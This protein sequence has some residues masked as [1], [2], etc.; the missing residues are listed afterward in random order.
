M[1]PIQIKRECTIIS[2]R[3]RADIED[4]RTIN[5]IRH[6]ITTFKGTFIGTT[7][8]G[9]DLVV[10]FNNESDAW[11]FVRAYEDEPEPGIGSY[12]LSIDERFLIDHLQTRH[13]AS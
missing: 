8:D 10:A 4:P 13:S 11:R 12:I 5:Q 7:G 9:Y 2:I 1:K 6:R 3:A